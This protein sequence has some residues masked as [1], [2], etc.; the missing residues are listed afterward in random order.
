[1]T[2]Q[3]SPDNASEIISRGADILG[4]HID[5]ERTAL[6]VRYIALILEWRR[7][8]SLTSLTRAVD[9][10]ALHF[11]DALS[12]FR[13][14]PRGSSANI[15]DVGTGAGFPGLVLR[16]ADDSLNVTVM[17]RDARKIVF[18]KHVV[19][20][21]GLT[22]VTFLNV[23]LDRVTSHPP[24]SLFDVAISRA[25]SSDPLVLDS[26]A[27]LLKSDGR[28]IRMAGPSSLDK[29]IS[30]DRFIEVD[31]WEGI[32]PFVERFRGVIVYRRIS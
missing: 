17:D 20:E 22:G 8:I 1:M 21:L 2:A 23:D 27:S 13:V 16:I 15:I 6:M 18:L 19:H 3:H 11:V 5:R 7:R 28:L 14:L 4:I 10:A 26:F 31:R 12:V 9:I 32:L 24:D 30:L 25:F 29:D